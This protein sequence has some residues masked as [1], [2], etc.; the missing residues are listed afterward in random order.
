MENFIIKL[1]EIFKVPGI[2]IAIL[3]FVWQQKFISIIKSSDTE[4]LFF[5]HEKKQVY[6]TFNWIV[7]YLITFVFVAIAAF[8][9]L[10]LI[11][12]YKFITFAITKLVIN[13][14]LLCSLLISIVLYYIRKHKEELSFLKKI[15]ENEGAFTIIF[16]FYYTI[17][18]LYVAYTISTGTQILYKSNKELVIVLSIGIS[19][20]LLPGILK[21]LIS[22][23]IYKERAIF[24]FNQ[25][26][27]V[28]FIL[29]LIKDNEFLVGDNS[30][31]VACKKIR[32]IS[33]EEIKKKDILIDKITY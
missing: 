18:I 6:N 8:A 21:S 14:L 26:G 15:N 20:F 12:K 16:S 29:K 33:Y 11:P 1:I 9:I 28:W 3:Y 27:D 19:C 24:S 23:W 4:K 2:I 31:E 10:F 13:L 32:F 7:L 22:P 25:D 30:D 5:T 17:I